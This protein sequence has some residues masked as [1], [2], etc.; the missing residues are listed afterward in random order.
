MDVLRY[1]MA[2]CIDVIKFCTGFQWM[3]IHHFGSY[4][5]SNLGLPRTIKNPPFTVTNE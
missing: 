2:S 1:D 5:D 4:A 3:I